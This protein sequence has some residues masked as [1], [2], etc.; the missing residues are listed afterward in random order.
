M[1]WLQWARQ[2]IR[3]PIVGLANRIADAERPAPL[4][5][6]DGVTATVVL[7]PCDA[8]DPDHSIIV[9]GKLAEVAVGGHL[10]L[11]FQ[12]KDGQPS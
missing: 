2:S 4:F 12:N 9:R 11:I 10:T 5:I 3:K 6:P 8:H 1:N 7:S